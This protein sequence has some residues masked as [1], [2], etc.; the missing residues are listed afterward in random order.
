MQTIEEFED[1]IRT[2]IEKVNNK[3]FEKKYKYFISHSKYDNKQDKIIIDDSTPYLVSKKNR[4]KSIFEK[5]EHPDV[6]ISFTDY[7]SLYQPLD[8][9]ITHYGQFKFIGHP[10]RMEIE[11]NLRDFA[12]ELVD[13]LCSLVKP[14]DTIEI[15]NFIANTLQ[16]IQVYSKIQ[17]SILSSDDY[18][19][20]IIDFISHCHDRLNWKFRK[21]L[22]LHA[23][24][25]TELEKSTLAFNLTKSTDVIALL[26]IL[27]ESG[28]TFN[29]PQDIFEF[30]LNYFS[31]YDK[32]MDRV[33]PIAS[34]MNNL[35]TYYKR[36]DSTENQKSLKRIKE[37]LTEHLKG[38]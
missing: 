1:I 33:V 2:S 19:F 38:I 12:I 5:V 35:K 10:E 13:E 6:G 15:N 21:Q 8:K 26:H 23:I 29:E 11:D 22:M 9:E 25:S 31:Y 18:K 17:M 37:I 32:K 36:I 34:N 4:R 24:N 7:C 16:M 3:W 14:N 20:A 28:L 27:I 30:A